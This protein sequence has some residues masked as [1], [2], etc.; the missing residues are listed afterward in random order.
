MKTQNPFRFITLFFLF[1]L[2]GYS[3]VGIGTTNVHP[4]AI[5]ELKSE[6]KGFLI[7]RMNTQEKDNISNPSAGLMIYCTDFCYGQGRLTVYDGTIWKSLSECPPPDIDNDGVLDSLDLDSDNDGILDSI[8]LIAFV[9]DS[10]YYEYYNLTPTANTLD[11]FPTIN[12]IDSGKIA[13]FN[14]AS[15]SIKNGNPS[16]NNFSIRYKGFITIPETANYTFSTLS[17]DGSRLII[18]NQTVVNN[19]GIHGPTTVTNTV[20]LTKGRHNFEV[21]FFEFAGQEILEIQMAKTGN[22]LQNIDFGILG[23]INKDIDNDGIENHLDM[24]SDGDGCWDALEGSANFSA[25]DL[26]PTSHRLLGS[27]DSNG[28]PSITNGGQEAFYSLNPAINACN[29]PLTNCLA[30]KNAGHNSDGVYPIDPDGNGG[31]APFNAYCDMTTDGGGWTLVLNYLHLGNTNPPLTVRDTNLPIQNSTTLGDNEA[32]STNENGSWGHASNSMMTALSFSNVRFYG[33][34]SGHN[35]IIHFKTS[36]PNVISYFKTGSGNC[37]G[38]HVP[39][40]GFVALSNH[41]SQ[42]PATANSGFNN[43][44][45]NAMTNFPFYAGASAHWGIGLWGRWEVDDFPNNSTLSTL[46]QIWIK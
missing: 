18:G 7:P 32:S 41:T 35:R 6:N 44:M 23:I 36:R 17:D 45:D 46:H 12:P 26:D 33:K 43:E 30:Y 42:I 4:S 13:N 8:E 11:N 31:L 24:D 21:L 37:S 40:T 34:T 1:Y 22:T 19:D 16:L 5:L 28:I 2:S 38:I 39:N 29:A 14:V 25:S 10:I 3:Q 27:V 9:T 15:L 20:N